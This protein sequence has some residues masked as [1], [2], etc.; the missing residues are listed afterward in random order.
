MSVFETINQGT[1]NT[2]A[3]SW[4][5]EVTDGANVLGTSAH[6]VKI[7][8]TGTTVQP[9]SESGTWTTTV[10]QPTAENLNAT[11]AQGGTWTVRNDDGS[12]NALTSS[13]G[14][15]DGNIKTIGGTA[16]STGTGGSGA[17]IPRVTVAN[18]SKME[19]WDGTNTLAVDGG[20]NAA[21]DLSEVGGGAV[22]LGAKTMAYSIPVAIATDQELVVGAV[23]TTQSGTKSSGV[24]PTTEGGTLVVMTDVWTWSTMVLT[25]VGTGA[26]SFG[27]QFQLEGSI[28]GNNWTPL[29]GTLQA[30]KPQQI[31][32]FLTTDFQ[33]I[34]ARYNLAGFPSIRV[35]TLAGF[36]GTINVEYALTTALG[37]ESSFAK[38][39]LIDASGASIALPAPA[40][41]Y[42][43]G[44]IPTGG[45]YQ[46]G[47]TTFTPVASGSQ[48]MSSPVYVLE[49]SPLIGD[50]LVV[51][52][53][54]AGNSGTLTT[55]NLS[56]M[57][58]FDSN[59][60][61]YTPAKIYDCTTTNL[62]EAVVMFVVP[63]TQL[64][65]ENNLGFNVVDSAVCPTSLSI[66]VHELQ[67]VSIG[68]LSCGHTTG[69]SGSS[70]T[71]LASPTGN[72][73]V[74]LLVTKTSG[75]E[76]IVPA[77]AQ[78]QFMNASFYAVTGSS[79]NPITYGS[80]T[81]EGYDLF[82]VAAPIVS[83]GTLAMGCYL[84]ETMVPLSVSASGALSTTTTIAG[85]TTSIPVLASQAGTWSMALTDPAVGS[86]GLTA[87]GSGTL[88]AATSYAGGT[89]SA[90][91]V[92]ASGNLRV[93]LEGS[94]LPTAASATGATVPEDASYTGLNI[95]GSLVGQTGFSLPS[96]TAAAVAI[97]DAAGNL[98]TIS[99]QQ[100]P[101]STITATPTGTVAMGS[102]SATNKMLALSTDATGALNTNIASAGTSLTNT[103][104][105]L[106]VNVT[107]G[108]SAPTQYPQGSSV[109]TPTGT[110]AMG[111]DYGVGLRALMCDV[112]GY[113]GVNVISQPSVTV[114]GTP[115]TVSVA[116]TSGGWSSNV[117]LALSTTP[118][119]VKSSAG[120]LGGYA[121]SNPNAGMVYVFW[122]NS[123]IPTVGSTTSLYYVIGV[124][125]GGAANIEFSLG[126]PLSSCIYVAASTSATSAVAPTTG[127]T[128]TT[129]YK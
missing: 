62:G 89:L 106:N 122:Y 33:T 78:S 120:Q 23:Y 67:N 34:S 16:P 85:S 15:L 113:L 4:P 40:A 18:D 103:A 128:V 38:T 36:T 14:S 28:D 121:I 70:L 126:V 49:K 102:Y 30:P 63:V 27:G 69:S 39:E 71:P 82:C 7:D 100:Y 124:P 74:T 98:A 76:P 52:L 56:G 43:D 73:P 64:D 86:L 129:L 13:A 32:Q 90:L 92:D 91:K 112:N 84:G 22:S 61:Y 108:V 57:T 111:L 116:A 3:N 107:G 105:A 31:T 77:Q 101:Q 55:A 80:V 95:A 127:V 12:G 59:N 72:Y 117:Q 54:A 93:G 26:I 96:S 41:Q 42:T 88:M 17:G 21:V 37:D 110:V 8:P 48:W 66:F 35:H 53:V 29:T 79:Y 19:L 44:S 125:G 2:P 24:V 87:P 6:P 115:T 20:G 51:A 5:V 99:N 97:V 45:L 60:N 10:T 9:V 119:A 68:A 58:L 123:V 11:A 104:G 94:T 118:V 1:P 109:T 50:T 83:K 47:S 65:S 25:F 114:S 46:S 81:N 75:G